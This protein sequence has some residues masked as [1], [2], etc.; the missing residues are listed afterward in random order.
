MPA[1]RVMG[2]QV[3]LADGSML[4][5]NGAEMGYQ[6]LKQAYSQKAQFQPLLYFTHNHS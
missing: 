5:V 1:C 4:I 2:D 6:G 3:L